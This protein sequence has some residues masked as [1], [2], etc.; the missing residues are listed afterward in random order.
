MSAVE[1]FDGGVIW[2]ITNVFAGNVKRSKP[3]I[4]QLNGQDVT[5][6]LSTSFTSDAT[7][8]YMHSNRLAFFD[9]EHMAGLRETIDSNR[10]V[11]IYLK[12]SESID[13]EPK[14]ELLAKTRFLL[15]VGD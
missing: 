7:L 8:M 2:T 3:F 5:F 1:Q 15:Q 9:R 10:Q 6:T 4:I 14:L 12:A 13:F 11:A